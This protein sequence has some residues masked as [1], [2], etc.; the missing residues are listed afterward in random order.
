MFLQCPEWEHCNYI[1]HLLTVYL[2]CSS[3]G[4]R[5]SPPVSSPQDGYVMVDDLLRR[6]L[7]RVPVLDGSPKKTDQTDPYLRKQFS[8]TGRTQMT[9]S[10]NDLLTPSPISISQK[11]PDATYTRMTVKNIVSGQLLSVPSTRHAR[12]GS[13]HRQLSWCMVDYDCTR[14][15]RLRSNHPVYI[16]Y[17]CNRISSI[18]APSS[19]FRLSKSPK[20][21]WGASEGRRPRVQ[22][23]N[24]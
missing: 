3:S 24:S 23:H 21:M 6:R 12:K 17:R 2:Q 19:C 14:P 15:S 4:H 5:F 11:G 16:T 1:V 7:A 18:V 22:H 13:H 8:S 9:Q 20:D 10:P